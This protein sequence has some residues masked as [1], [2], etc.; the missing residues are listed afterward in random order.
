MPTMIISDH[1]IWTKHIENGENL[2]RRLSSLEANAPIRLRI[3][4]KPVLFRKMRNGAD[5]RPTPGVR[6]DEAFKD[7]W[8]DLYRNRRGQRIDVEPDEGPQPNSY[9]AAVSEL[10]AEWHSPQDEEAYRD[11]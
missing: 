1:T 6:P 7:F 9:L 11:L 3:D 2:V 5:G 8:N 10:M 4:G